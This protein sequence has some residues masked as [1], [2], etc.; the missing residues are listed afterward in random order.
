MTVSVPILVRLLYIKNAAQLDIFSS[1]KSTHHQKADT[2]GT[3]R[4]FRCVRLGGLS[5]LLILK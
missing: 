1:Q 5:R 2:Q 3:G 4:E